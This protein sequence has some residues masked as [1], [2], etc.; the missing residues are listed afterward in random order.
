MDFAWYCGKCL[1][2]HWY[3]LDFTCVVVNRHEVWV[4]ANAKGC[5]RKHF[6]WK[7]VW[8]SVYD[9]ECQKRGLVPRTEVF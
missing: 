5:F 8:R 3:E 7:K 9:A 2:S 1:K 4:R 6:V